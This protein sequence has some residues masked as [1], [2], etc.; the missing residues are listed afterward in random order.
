MSLIRARKR[1]K[2]NWMDTRG[3]MHQRKLMLSLVVVVG[4]IW[5]LSWAF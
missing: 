5:Y 3:G 1:R 4:V 2:A